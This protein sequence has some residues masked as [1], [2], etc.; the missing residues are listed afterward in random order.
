M[1]ATVQPAFA[2]PLFDRRKTSAMV[3]PASTSRKGIA[4]TKNISTGT[5]LLAVGL[6]GPVLSDAQGRSGLAQ[7]RVPVFARDMR[8]R[9]L[10]RQLGQH[11]AKVAAG[12][13]G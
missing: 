13:G 2:P 3:T 12:P 6:G 4:M 1:M 9:V 10:R 11:R 8:R 5:P 7:G